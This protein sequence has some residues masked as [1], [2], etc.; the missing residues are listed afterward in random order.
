VALAREL[1]GE[2]ELDRAVQAA[3]PHAGLCGE[4]AAADRAALYRELTEARYRSVR[5][6]C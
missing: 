5:R 1:S 4:H 6:C 3:G 2:A